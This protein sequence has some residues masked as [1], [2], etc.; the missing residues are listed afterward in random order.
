MEEPISIVIVAEGYANA[1]ERNLPGVLAQQYA[2]GFEV[3]VV[4]ESKK[5]ETID[6]ETPLMAQYGNI[7]STYIPDKPQYITDS[8]V[9][10]MLGTKAAKHDNIV[11]IHPLFEVPSE[12]WLQEVAAV[13]TPTI[14][15]GTPF[16]DRKFGFIGKMRHNSRTAKLIKPWLKEHGDSIKDHKLKKPDNA[17]FSMLTRARNI[18]T[19][20]NCDISYSDTPTHK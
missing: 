9:A 19:I 13:L 8:E 15:I 1:L 7:S 6:V 11:I 17:L 5:G 20:Q 2:P 3:I 18:S 4:R 10:I 14:T 12:N 16:Y